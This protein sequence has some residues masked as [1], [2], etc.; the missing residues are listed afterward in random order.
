[1]DDRLLYS[2]WKKNEITNKKNVIQS[3]DHS[4]HAILNCDLWAW[5][6]FFPPSYILAN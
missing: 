3:I 4:L 2:K 1:M 6:M 5:Y